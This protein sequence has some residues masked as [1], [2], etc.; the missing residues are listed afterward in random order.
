[1]PVP[2][3]LAAA[4]SN[5]TSMQQALCGRGSSCAGNGCPA[6]LV[7]AVKD[8]QVAIPIVAQ[9]GMLHAAVACLSGH[10]I[11]VRLGIWHVVFLR[12]R[13]AAANVRCAPGSVAQPVPHP[14]LQQPVQAMADLQGATGVRQSLAMASA[15]ACGQ[16]SSGAPLG[17]PGP[18][19]LQQS[20]RS[21][22]GTL[23]AEGLN[24]PAPPVQRCRWQDSASASGPARPCAGVH[25][26]PHHHH[27]SAPCTDS[28]SRLS[29]S[30]MKKL[31]P[32]GASS[33]HDAP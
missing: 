11:K 24:S 23:H 8:K 14:V 5:A 26:L 31:P 7:S 9:A 29:T 22:R 3:P 2:W 1:M 10:A 32:R 28:C 20:R 27:S 4:P 17:P 15:P 18:T 33:L 25:A 21:C 16:S 12:H 30:T 6:P 19:P 13:P